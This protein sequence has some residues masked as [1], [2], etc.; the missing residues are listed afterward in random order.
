MNSEHLYDAAQH[1]QLIALALI[2]FSTFVI[3]LKMTDERRYFI[4]FALGIILSVASLDMAFVVPMAM[5]IETPAGLVHSSVHKAAEYGF[6]VSVCI[7]VT[8]VLRELPENKSLHRGI[9]R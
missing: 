6:A 8:W 2:A 9:D 3:H 4:A 7:A 5:N 1:Y